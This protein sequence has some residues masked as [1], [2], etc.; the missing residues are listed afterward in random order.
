LKKNQFIIAL[1]LWLGLVQAA[2][3]Q[4]SL[5]IKIGQLLFVGFRGLEANA[6]SPVVQDIRRRHIGGVIL[7]DYDVAA[8]SPV[9]NIQSA[10]Q[11]KRLTDSLQA[12]SPIPLF[13]GIDQEGGRVSRLKTKFGFPPTVSAAYLGSLNNADTTRQ[14]A[15]QTATLLA[16]LGINVNFAPDADLNTNPMNPIIG[17]LDRSFSADP[18]I[19][20]MQAGMVIDEHHKQNVLTTLKHFC[21]HGSSSEDSH[22]GFVDVSKTWQ[23][24]ELVPYKVLIQSGKADMVMTAHIVNRALGDT[25]PVTLSH[26]MITG[27]LRDSLKFQGVVVSD[28]MQMNAIAAY[29]GLEDAIR[30]ALNAGVD[31]LVFAN[32]SFFVEDIAS[33]ATTII[34]SLVE[35]G[36]VSRERI[37]DAFGRIQRLKTK[38]RRA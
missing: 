3:A 9:R 4:D 28:D 5:D 6:Q 1:M 32:N 36:L 30:L 24:A 21:G 17:R 14:Y 7:F 22:E 20:A 33:Q 38:L 27:V 8:R 11:L 15:A 25:L 10:A 13:I 26:K 29:Y 16:T 34:R 31:M 37:D 19:V 18:N 2:S 23:P 35:R 12:A